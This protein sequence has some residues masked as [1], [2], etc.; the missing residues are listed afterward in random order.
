MSTA[1][2]VQLEKPGAGIP[3]FERLL[4]AWY[5][6]PRGARKSSWDE[7]VQWFLKEGDR[8]LAAIAPLTVEQMEKP[9]LI[10]RMRGL[11]DSSR[12]WSVA[13]TVEHI[14]IV[15]DGVSRA[16]VELTHNR[17]PDYDPQ[18]IAK[19]KPRRQLA[20]EVTAA[21]FRKFL[22]VVSNRVMGEV[23]DRESIA[24]FTH[25]WFGRMTARQWNWMLS[26][27]QRLHRQ[28]IQKIIEK[29]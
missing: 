27:H 2:L 15:G 29:L 22:T 12:F 20:G 5:F 26:A 1:N 3:F 8:I 19:V 7:T 17:V 25:P 16:V 18:I 28:Q 9:V 10:N 4:A 14:M 24:R 6:M 13:M 23:G 21:E 11:E